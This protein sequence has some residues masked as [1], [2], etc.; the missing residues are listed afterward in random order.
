MC[1]HNEFA[2]NVKVSRLKDTEEGPVT[3]YAADVTIQCADC[4]LPFQFVGLPGGVRA[5]KPTTSADWCE[6]RLPIQPMEIEGFIQRADY[7]LTIV[8]N[9]PES[10]FMEEGASLQLI[11]HASQGREVFCISKEQ[12]QILIAL[13]P[14]QCK[15]FQQEF[16]KVID[17]FYQ[18]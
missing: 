2:V 16:D 5:D 1:E 13:S 11:D 9:E 6:A 17:R 12:M 15:Q 8:P 14:E 7:P 10:P 3:H 18:H 4:H